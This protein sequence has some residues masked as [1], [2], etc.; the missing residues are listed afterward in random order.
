MSEMNLK[1]TFVLGLVLMGAVVKIGFGNESTADELATVEPGNAKVLREYAV[2]HRLR[3]TNDAS[4]M[5]EMLPQPVLAWT[6]PTRGD[7]FGGIFLWVDG[8]RPI[9]YGGMFVWMEQPQK[10]LGRE[11]HV[12]SPQ[13][14]TVDFDNQAVW[15]P[16]AD[17]FR[18]Q[19][20]PNLELRSTTTELGRL[21]SMKQIANRFTIEI[22]NR[23]VNP[24]QVRLLPTPI[25]RYADR[26]ADI[27]DG[28]IFAFVQG[29]DPEVLLIV[30]AIG[31]VDKSIAF[32]YAIARCTTWAVDAS[33]EGTSVYAVPRYEFYQPDR[34]ASFIALPRVSVQ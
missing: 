1:M 25:Y 18:F 21:R 10:K 7:V 31:Q 26:E 34:K 11:F 28:A 14:I 30:E 4:R 24:E 13:Q 12:L 15:S 19:S 32:R 29:N 22:T 16:T 17:D 33:F 6:N 20:V 2:R 5:V 23:D 8:R 27:V 3:S 9:A